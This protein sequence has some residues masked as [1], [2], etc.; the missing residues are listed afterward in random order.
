M[1][2]Q[3]RIQDFP[4]KGAS[5]PG[6]ANIPFDQFSRELHKNKEILAKRRGRVRHVPLR[7]ATEYYGESSQLEEHGFDP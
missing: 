4:E 6:S 7:S 2:M 1:N 5:T 3:W